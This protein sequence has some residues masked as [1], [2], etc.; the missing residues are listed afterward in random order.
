MASNAHA[1]FASYVVTRHVTEYMSSGISE[2]RYLVFTIA[3][4]FEI[5]ELNEIPPYN[6]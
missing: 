6:I 2:I 4:T 1:V 5:I 3:D